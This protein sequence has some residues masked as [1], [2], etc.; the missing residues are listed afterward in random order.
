MGATLAGSPNSSDPV[1]VSPGDLELENLLSGDI[2]TEFTGNPVC[3]RRS[4]FECSR[5]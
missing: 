5:E 3:D 1:A 2:S 4:I